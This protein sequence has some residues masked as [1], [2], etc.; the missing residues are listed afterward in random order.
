MKDYFL[1][2]LRQASTSTQPFRDA[3][4]AL[5]RIL[6]AEAAANI[7][8][9]AI[10]IKTPVG[11]SFGSRLPNGII[12]ATIL[13]AGLAMLPAFE[14]LFPA[15]PVGFFG[16]R[17]DEKTA[18]PHL[19]YQNLP[20]ITSQDWIL[21]VDPMLATGGSAMTALSKLEES[22]ATMTQTILVSIIAS[23]PG[24]EAIRKHFPKVKIISGATDPGLNDRKF[25]VPGL[26]DF[27]DR[28]FGT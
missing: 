6:A 15:S 14:E 3:A 21:L 24:V 9:E 18:V 23:T 4:H 2:T 28:Y 10:Q 12:L 20:K 1:T 11:D 27:G 19:Y 17:R 5:S 25:I 16:I 7:P 22:C 26:G 13:R 8:L